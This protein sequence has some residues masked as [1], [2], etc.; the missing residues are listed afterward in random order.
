MKIK[1]PYTL[2]ILLPI[3]GWSVLCSSFSYFL[4][5]SLA[6]FSNEIAYKSFLYLFPL[7]V[8]IFGILGLLRY[9][10]VKFWREEQIKI[11]NNNISSE[12]RFR[13]FGTEDIKK[14]FNSLIYIANSTTVN[15]LAGGL[16]V[17]VLILLTV[18][19]N[20]ATSFDLIVIFIGGIIA[21]F[22]S[23][24]FST[25]FCQ[26]AMFKE[27]KECRKILVERGENIEN[28]QLSSIA[29]KFYFL[30]FLPFFTVF[31][32]LLFVPSFSFS[33]AMLCLLAL[34]MTFIIDRV[35]FIYLSNALNELEG[36]AKE[37]PV[38]ERAVFITGSLDKEIVNLSEALNKASEQIYLSK[39][40]LEDSKEE[41]AK[42]VEEL[43]K[44]FKLTVNRELKMIELKKCIKK[45]QLKM[46]QE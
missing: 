36:F 40:E 44:F 3:I 30:F 21:I 22:F 42:R 26:Q 23:C 4:I 45:L 9:G 5:I 29:P 11:V 31:I 8:I 16:S 24:A 2:N 27:V 32:V 14:T 13:V 38:G 6:D 18:W 17:I 41:M 12:G 7:Y 37:L 20:Q 1:L 19:I 10:G 15:I 35:L 39:K 28:V 46:G 43:E 34:I 25:F 33:A